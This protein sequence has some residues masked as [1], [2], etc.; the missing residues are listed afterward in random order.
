MPEGGGNSQPTPPLT[1][2]S[3]ELR[4]IK[5]QLPKPEYDWEDQALGVARR[6]AELSFEVF[7]TPS[8]PMVVRLSGLSTPVANSRGKASLCLDNSFPMSHF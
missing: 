7:W 2:P 1:P 4:V 8:K 5:A 6:M 3:C